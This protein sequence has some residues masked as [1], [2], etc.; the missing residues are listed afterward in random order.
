VA[1]WPEDDTPI[2]ALLCVHL[3]AEVTCCITPGL[4]PLLK[5]YMLL[6]LFMNGLLHCVSRLA[7]HKISARIVCDNIVD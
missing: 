3:L 6:C 4:Q 5:D 7:K 1:G 2:C